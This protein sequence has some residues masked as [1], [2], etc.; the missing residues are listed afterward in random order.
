MVTAADIDEK[1]LY[2]VM[3]P[4]VMTEEQLV[5]N[6]YPRPDPAQPG[7]VVMKVEGGR[8]RAK[9]DPEKVRQVAGDEE[10]RICDRC[11]LIYQVEP[12]TGAQVGVERCVHHWGRLFRKRGNRGRKIFLNEHTLYFNGSTQEIYLITSFCKYDM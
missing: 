10:K 3:K 9:V 1:L 7:R 11:G 6:G 12:D 4:Y 5:D 8:Y 2:A